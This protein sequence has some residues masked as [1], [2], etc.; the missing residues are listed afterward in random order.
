MLRTIVD[1]N[2]MD[3]MGPPGGGGNPAKVPLLRHYHS[4]ALAEIDTSSQGY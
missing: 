3:D 1:E 2:K 4:L